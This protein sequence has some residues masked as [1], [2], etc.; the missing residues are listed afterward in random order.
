MDKQ[1]AKTDAER[2]KALRARRK[3]EGMVLIREWV[4]ISDK[5]S[6]MA[7]IARKK[8]KK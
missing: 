2:Q 8:E 7:Y 4:H 6:I 5:P 3:L 1:K